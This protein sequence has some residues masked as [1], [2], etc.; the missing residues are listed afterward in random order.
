MQNNLK[1]CMIAL[2]LTMAV[3]PVGAQVQ[4]DK[5]FNKLKI[6]ARA[7]G[8]LFTTDS[9]PNFGFHGK[10][11]NLMLGGDFGHGFSYYFKQRIIA[12]AGSVM[13]FDNTDF[14]YLDYKPTENWRLR[15]GKDAMAM[16]G[17]EYDASPIDVYFPTTLWNSIYCF[18]LGVSG[19][20]ISNDGNHT[21]VAQV[22]NSPYINST[23]L[24][25]DAGLVAYNLCW[26]GNVDHWHT[27]W[28]TSMIE[29]EWGKFMNLT[30]FGNK[31]TFDKWDIY[32]DFMHH[33]LAF[34]DWGKNFGIVSCANYYFTPEFNIFVKGMFEQNKSEVD[35]NSA[36][37]LD[38]LLLAGHTYARY[39][40]GFEYFPEGL[41]NVRLH[42][43]VCRME[44]WDGTT[45]I[46]NTWNFNI[47]ATWSM[48]YTQ[49]FKKQ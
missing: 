43:Y 19:A 10:Y 1:T 29:R 2:L 8:E 40:L 49:L 25:Y 41:K 30:M 28:S 48:D 36:V 24:N 32:V 7:D 37:A 26:Y 47:G 38:H 35:L 33:A 27:I 44:E 22:T 31:L 23:G 45:E 42:T 16:G 18:Q 9:T 14:L 34:N 4:W 3:L 20:Y 13:F 5:A 6:E 21:L 46:D 11:F 15:F 39:G 12:N 17:F